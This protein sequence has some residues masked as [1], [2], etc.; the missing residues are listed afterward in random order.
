[1]TTTEVAT[2]IDPDVA[3]LVVAVAIV[4]VTLVYAIY[5]T[6][7]IGARPTSPDAKRII[8]LVGTA[9][10]GFRDLAGVRSNRWPTS[11]R[12]GPGVP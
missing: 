3:G 1:M 11:V 10:A 9:A 7:G 12:T 2:T 6:P 5:V 4:T 8:E